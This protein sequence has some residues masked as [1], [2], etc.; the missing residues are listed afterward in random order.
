M[1]VPRSFRVSIAFCA[2]LAVSWFA[3]TGCSAR[4]E[5]PLR[6]GAIV[7]P[8]YECLFLARALGKFEQKP[9]KLVEYPSS[10]EVIRSFRNGAIEVAA[11]TS[12]EFLRLSAEEPDVCA[13]LVMDVSNGAD[14]ILAKPEF[15]DLEALRGKRVAVEVN[16]TGVFLLSRALG[17]AGLSAKDVEIVPTENNSHA[18]VFQ[19]GKVD[20]VVTFEP[21]RSELLDRGAHTVFDSSRIPGEIA[22][23]LVV[24][25]SLIEERPAALKLLVQSWFEARDFLTREK[26]R[27]CELMAAREHVTPGA[28]A[29]SLN[30]LEIPSLAKNRQMLRGDRSAT[31]TALTKMHDIMLANGMVKSAAPGAEVLDGRLLP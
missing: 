26:P 31:H 28:F 8:G 1:P 17:S 5:P 27:A 22:D 24:H 15:K 20:A 29:R 6:V 16:S 18:A 2:A 23:F 13:I 14:T 9:V 30:L 3:L 25:K 19:Q 7:W 4:P 21:H 12:D 10:P 11:I